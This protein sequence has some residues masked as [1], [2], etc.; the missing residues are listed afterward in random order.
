MPRGRGRCIVA[1][2]HD[3][4]V[5]RAEPDPGDHPLRRVALTFSVPSPNLL[6]SFWPQP[7]AAAEDVAAEIRQALAAPIGGPGL[8]ELVAGAGQVL[9]IGDDGTRPTPPTSSC[10]S[11]WT[12]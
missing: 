9:T 2:T 7:V 1:G 6:G 4:E 10:R 5:T 11:S 8:A 3:M 12:P